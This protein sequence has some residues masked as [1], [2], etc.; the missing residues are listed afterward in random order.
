MHLPW[1]QYHVGPVKIIHGGNG[2]N[3]VEAI[4]MATAVAVVAVNDGRDS[5]SRDGGVP[6]QQ[7]TI[8]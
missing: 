4:M 6:A 3:S 5:D 8:S 1:N 7:A 2:G